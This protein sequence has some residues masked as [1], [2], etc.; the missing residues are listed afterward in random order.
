MNNNSNNKIINI[1]KDNNEAKFLEKKDCT[2]ECINRNNLIIYLEQGIKESR[3]EIILK[4]SGNFSWP[5]NKTKLIYDKN[6]N[7]LG[8]EFILYPQEP[9]EEKKYYITLFL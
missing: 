7:I 1:I 9:N 4:N 6:L 3:I 2:C 8:N 5:K